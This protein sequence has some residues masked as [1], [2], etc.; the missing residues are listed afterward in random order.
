MS[1]VR[2]QGA[3]FRVQ[4]SVGRSALR[5]VLPYFPRSGPSGLVSPVVR[6][7]WFE[8]FPLAWVVPP[9][10]MQGHFEVVLKLSC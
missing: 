9:P 1:G 3:G 10:P 6:R 5:S 7:E 8:L 4:G 2:G